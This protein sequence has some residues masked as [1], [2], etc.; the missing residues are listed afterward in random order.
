MKFYL[1]CIFFI[2][3][4]LSAQITWA[5]DAAEVIYNNCTSCHNPNGIGPVSYMTY[6][7]AYAN[8]PN[9]HAMDR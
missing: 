9:I 2:S 7:D 5:D 4:Q 1:L 8:A 6:N 3:T